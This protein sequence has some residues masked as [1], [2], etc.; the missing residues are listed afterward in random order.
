M[1]KPKTILVC[2]IVTGLLFILFDMIIAIATSPIFL[3]YSELAIWKTPPNIS[4]GLVFD[5][6]NGFILVA[7]YT[8]LYNGIPGVGWPRGFNYGIIVGLFRVVMT[9]FSSIVMYN[10]PSVLI[11]TS[12]LTGY[13]EIVIVCVLLAV[14]YERLNGT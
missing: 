4:A 11:V 13:I 3:P 8:V 1:M 12:L 10:I 6:I 5:F 9:A 14:I 2:G 7:V